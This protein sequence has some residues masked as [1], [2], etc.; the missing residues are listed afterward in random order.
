MVTSLLSKPTK[1]DLQGGRTL[2]LIF[3]MLSSPFKLFVVD[4][5]SHARTNLLNNSALE[6]YYARTNLFKCLVSEY[7]C[8]KP[9][10]ILCLGIVF[11]Y[12][13]LI[14]LGT[15]ISRDCLP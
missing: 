12:D 7:Y 3:Q 14:I 9:S 1:T 8:V 15:S 4:R 10:Q 5:F 2:F 6:Y 13:K 11:G